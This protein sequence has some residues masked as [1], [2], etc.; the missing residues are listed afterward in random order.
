V[1]LFAGDY[2]AEVL[3]APDLKSLDTQPVLFSSISATKPR[4]TTSRRRK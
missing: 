3:D 1:R 2:D 4:P